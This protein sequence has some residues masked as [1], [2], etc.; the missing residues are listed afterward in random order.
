MTATML[1]RLRSLP[2]RSKLGLTMVAGGFAVLAIVAY[3]SFGY[4]HDQLVSTAR[5]QALVSATTAQ[6]T[7]RSAL[8]RGD[9][10]AARQT[11]RQL[12][13]TQ[14]VEFV[15]VYAADGR[16]IL[17][18]DEEE[19]GSRPSRGTWLPAAGELPAAGVARSMD[20]GES[21]HVFMPIR[22]AQPAVMELEYS[23]APLRAAVRRG[24]WM[25]IGLV[26]LGLFA[27]GFVVITM[28][29]RE[30]VGPLQRMGHLLTDAGDGTTPPRRAR[31]ELQQIEASMVRLIRHRREVEAR[32]A[33][34]SQREG[35]A[36]VGE[37]AAE[38][39][40]EFKRPLASIRSAM[41]LLEQEY[42]MD[43]G[44]RDV[45]DSMHQQLE[46]LSD[47]MRDL[48]SLARPMPHDRTAIDA[49][50]VIDDALLGL[51]GHPALQNVVIQRSYASDVPAIAMEPRRIQQAIQNVVLNAAEAMPNGG[52]ITVT[53]H[54]DD[55][56]LAIGVRD[57]GL[58]MS[59]EAIQQALRPFH[60]TKANGTGL[61]LP[62]VVRI[63]TAHGGELAIDSTPGAG[64][65]VWLML[66][67]RDAPTRAA[68]SEEG[69]WANVS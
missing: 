10:D 51:M 35:F 31:D 13:A 59:E 25:G 6:A 54:A 20:D 18:S 49:R 52:T 7:V 62:L 9:E 50:E 65:T 45:L 58:G 2:L 14:S 30:V 28:L 57:T 41:D 1:N 22:I 24:M 5:E 37:L 33:A 34:A 29:E 56:R 36:Q 23:M 16:V 21:V 38:M 63:L 47:T 67:V 42:V 64:T 48:F 53:T 69:A 4:W 19:E 55:G 11:L 46:R 26:L 44:S 27:L 60:S 66:P 68:P 43:P 40:H 32:A 15:R 3:V 8:S 39:A 17:S 61:G 12:A